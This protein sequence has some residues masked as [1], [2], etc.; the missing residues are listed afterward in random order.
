MMTP[1]PNEIYDLI[2]DT[3]TDPNFCLRAL[4]ELKSERERRAELEEENAA[5]RQ[6]ILNQKSSIFELPKD[7]KIKDDKPFRTLRLI[8]KQ[9]GYTMKDLARE[10]DVGYSNLNMWFNGRVSWTVARAYQVMHILGIP[11]EEFAACF[12][13]DCHEGK[14]NS[15]TVAGSLRKKVQNQKAK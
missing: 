2:N 13:D 3:L 1:T 10:C 12:P 7:G 11:D 5:L 15:T 9:R 6:S 8:M 4:S 14:I